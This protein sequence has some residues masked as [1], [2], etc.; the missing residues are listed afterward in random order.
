M[1]H[2]LKFSQVFDQV[3]H[4]NVCKQITKCI[5]HSLLRNYYALRGITK[6]LLKFYLASP[7]PLISV[8]MV[9]EI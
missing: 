3:C 4:S 5:G 8:H 6:H 2:E 7:C 9:S 1:R